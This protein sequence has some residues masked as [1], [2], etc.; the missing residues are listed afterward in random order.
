MQAQDVMTTNVITV[1]PQA[2][3][4]EVAT[5][6]L[7]KGI[8]ALPVVDREGNLVGIV[9]EGDLM[10]RVD[11]GNERRRSW[12]LEIFAG[13]SNEALAK[14]YVKAHACKVEDLMTRDVITAPP[15]VTLRHLAEL[16]ER[17]RIKRVPIVQDG[18]IVGIV[19]R[20][21]L[22]QALATNG[23]QSKQEVG[24]TDTIIRREVLD[25]FRSHDWSKYLHLNATVHDGTVA[26]W[27]NVG[28]ESEKQ[29]ARVTAEL[30]PGVRVVENNI[31]VLPVV[32]GF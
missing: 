5:F 12:W 16:L 17:N 14:D 22:I 3:V 32:A 20:A 27:G 4:R 29:A 28:S 2:S 9:S 18:K 7:V 10:R 13:R 26:L 23:S 24:R 11:P 25:H 30:V 19:S 8:S 6:M 21:N 31:T 15:A 1:D